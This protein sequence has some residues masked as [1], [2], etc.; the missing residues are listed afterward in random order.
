MAPHIVLAP[1][2]GIFLISLA[3]HSPAAAL[4]AVQSRIFL[5]IHPSV[6]SQNEAG[7][8]PGVHRHACGLVPMVAIPT[9][10]LCDQQ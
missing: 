5:V 6:A 3:R 8:T 9:F 2:S 10:P 7:I 1:L 4:R